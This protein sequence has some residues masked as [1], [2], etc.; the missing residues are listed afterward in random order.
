MQS[1]GII[2]CWLTMTEKECIDYSYSVQKNLEDL[3]LQG[4]YRVYFWN[5]L[6]HDILTKEDLRDESYTY[7][8]IL[9]YFEHKGERM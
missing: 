6:E 8:F 1:V 4:V 7:M 2:I 3:D 5:L 9:Q